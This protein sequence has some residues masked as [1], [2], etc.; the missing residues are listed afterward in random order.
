MN[1][2]KV[3]MEQRN[4]RIKR[5][6][7]KV[8]GTGERP[9]LAVFRSLKH[10]DVQIID[11]VNGKTLVAASDRDIKDDKMTKTEKAL[12]V[13]KLI[14]EKAKTKNISAVVF[15]RRDKRYHGRVKAVAEGAREAGLVF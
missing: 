1:T 5:V 11:D 6:R 8:K 2:M 7:S 4:R 14:A 3:K 12:Q 9:R 13:G 10:V 15:D